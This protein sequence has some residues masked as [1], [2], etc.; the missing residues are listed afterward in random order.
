ME[1]AG[2][3]RLRAIRTLT[4]VHDALAAA[5]AMSLGFVMRL[6]VE[7]AL[8]YWPYVIAYTAITSTIGYFVGLN[9]GIWRYAS[10]SD[11]EAILKTAT[12]SILAFA[13]LMFLGNR[14]EHFPRTV[15]VASWSFTILLLAGSRIAYR[16]WKTRRAIE[17]GA[18]S[19][20]KYALIIGATD[21][22]ETFVKAASEGRVPGYRVAGII[23]ERGR[24]AGRSIRGVRILDTLSNLDTV[25]SRLAKDGVIIDSLVLAGNASTRGKS[26]DRVAKIAQKHNIVLRRLP[27]IGPQVRNFTEKLILQPL[28]LEDLLPRRAVTLGR[29]ELR[30][31]FS[32]ATVL[33]TGAGGSIGSELCRQVLQLKPKRMVLLDSSEYLLHEIDM[34][35]STEARG[36]EIVP[37]IGNVRDRAQMF[38]FFEAYR[39][40]I[41][42]HSAALKHVPIVERQPLEGLK[43]NVIGT[44]NVAD[45]AL[46]ISARAMVLVSSDK[47]VRPTSMMGASKR[48]AEMYCQALDVIGKT[49][50]VTVRFGNVLG[51]AGSVVPLFARQIAA[52]GPVT[53]THPDIERYFMTIPEAAQLVL[54]ATWH[55]VSSNGEDRGRIFVLDMG[56]PV[57]I[58]DIARRM[59]RLEGLRPGDDI[60]IE[61]IGLR[62]GEKM[63]EELFQPNE[64]LIATGTDGVLAAAPERQYKSEVLAQLL[65][66]LRLATVEDSEILS[67]QIMRRLVPEY[68]PTR[69]DA[70]G[71]DGTAASSGVNL[72]IVGDSS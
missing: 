41:V 25:I 33:V 4:L 57:R 44:R 56:A 18:L 59:I 29:D 19:D 30:N 13:L 36:V 51:S 22:A 15:M 39:P 47:A 8:P 27:D 10:I 46:S 34:A 42:F 45:A 32:D 37:L 48:A 53:V 58:V 31:L 16:V 40:D 50:F 71:A 5:F 49:H 68:A 20:A 23:D 54:H 28:A 17:H 35:L 63:F 38:R 24:R 3:G 6:G 67:E 1:I 7:A 64:Q 65:E 69:T 2:F 66:Q 43:T 70:G 9:N 60:A 26:F 14:L 72:S 61:F 55:G 21:D 12:A 11:L 62:P 52:G